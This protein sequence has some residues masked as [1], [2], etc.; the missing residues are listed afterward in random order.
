MVAAL[1]LSVA[2]VAQAPAAKPQ[3]QAPPAAPNVQETAQAKPAQ[4]PVLAQLRAYATQKID[5]SLSKSQRAALQKK[6]ARARVLYNQ[7]L[8]ELKYQA[9]AE[10]DQAE[11]ERV[12]PLLLKQQ[13]IQAQQS[14][15]QSAM[16][17][18]A[19]TEANARANARN[20]EINN[21]RAL[22]ERYP[23]YYGGR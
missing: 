17:T 7:R 13:E 3:P 18:A 12:L 23:E 1:I 14:Q 20:A 21:Q 22:R 2:I 16:R 15:A 11:Y 6:I 10:A 5:P 4:D 9:Q 19:A 8:Q